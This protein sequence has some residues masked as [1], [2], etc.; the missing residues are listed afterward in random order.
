MAYIN[1]DSVKIV[2]A[3]EE[4]E[5]TSEKTAK[6]TEIVLSQTDITAN[7]ISIVEVK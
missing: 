2:V 7:K 4:G 3:C 5:L 1:G 6:I